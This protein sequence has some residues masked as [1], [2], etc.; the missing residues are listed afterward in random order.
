MS[1]QIKDIMKNAEID[2]NDE[3]LMDVRMLMEKGI[4]ITA[5]NIR[6]FEALK[7]FSGKDTEYIADSAKRS[8]SRRQKDLWMQCL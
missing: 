6:Y 5:D 8:G 7:N 1:S 3:N 4:S 2:V